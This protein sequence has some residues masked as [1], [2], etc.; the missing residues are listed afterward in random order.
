[1]LRSS[2]IHGSS[3][4]QASSVLAL[5]ALLVGWFLN[6]GLGH[7]R[8]KRRLVTM[9][10]AV[11][12]VTLPAVGPAHAWTRLQN[13]YPNGPSTCSPCLKTF[14]TAGG[15]RYWT[16][17]TTWHSAWNTYL[18][19]A[20]RVWNDGAD[21][22]VSMPI[23][24]RGAPNSGPWHWGVGNLAPGFCGYAS[25]TWN[26]NNFLVSTLYNLDN[27]TAYDVGWPPASGH[28]FLQWT[29]AHEI[30]HSE[31]L[32]HSQFSTALMRPTQWNATRPK[33]DE[34]A[35]LNAIYGTR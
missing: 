7:R 32:G 24:V 2:S 3:S 11:A 33:G 31:S 18:D 22:R 8:F 6:G 21:T 1:M 13:T 25:Y 34:S 29:L 14:V 28:C 17:T 35:A 16:S 27:G 10:L 9:V 23:F 20:Y 4:R 19:A 30:G 5:G 12:L 26:G 15:N